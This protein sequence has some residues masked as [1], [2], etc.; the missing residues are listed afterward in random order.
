MEKKEI[1]SLPALV[2]TRHRKP[3]TDPTTRNQQ[4]KKPASSG[5]DA[6][7]FMAVPFNN[8]CLVRNL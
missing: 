7:F 8:S 2:Q 1:I 5:N 3:P 4:I 6:G